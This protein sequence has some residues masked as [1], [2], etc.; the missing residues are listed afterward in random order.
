M[1]VPLFHTAFPDENSAFATHLSPSQFRAAYRT[2]FH[3]LHNPKLDLSI[4]STAFTQSSVFDGLTV[5]I[6]ACHSRQV[7]GDRGST[8]RQRAQLILM[9]S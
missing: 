2:K 6:S 4:Q 1:P 3:L 8:P 7:A 9:S 5:M